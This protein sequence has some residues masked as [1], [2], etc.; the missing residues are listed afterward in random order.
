PLRLPEDA[1][2]SPVPFRRLRNIAPELGVDAVDLAGG[3]VMEDFDG[4]GWLDLVS[5]TWDPCAPMKAFRN[6]GRGGFVDVTSDWGLDTQLGAFNL[7]SG[8][9]DEDGMV[10]L[11]V[12]RGGWLGE[13]GRIRNSLLRND[14]DRETGRFVDVTVSAG[15]AY[16]AYPTQTAGWADYD[17]DGDLDLFVGNETAET[18]TTNPQ[19][20]SGGSAAYPSQLFRNEGDGSFTEIARLAGVTNDRYTKSVAWGD[21][22]DDGDPDLYVSNIGPNRLYR[23]D[24]PGEDGIVQFTDVAPEL[25]VVEPAAQSFGAWFFD[26]DN[27]GDLDLWVGRY[28]ALIEEVSASYLGYQPTG[29]SPVLYRNDGDTFTDVSKEVGLERPLL[30]MGANYGDLDNDGYPDVY[31]GTGVPDPDALM[32]N[33]LYHNQRG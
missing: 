19:T 8:D 30:P 4:D 23:N 17:G 27:D 16:P 33:V 11:L 14:L 26:Y 3:A 10:D 7:E 28:G 5:G 24:G 31:L 12:L 6:D 21:Y 2:E 18:E 22:D 32:P 29:Q 20:L 25:G 9:F 15:L 13:D 1:L